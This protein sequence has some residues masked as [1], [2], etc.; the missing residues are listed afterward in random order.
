MEKTHDPAEAKEHSTQVA[1]PP[2]L[3]WLFLEVRSR[4]TAQ[5]FISRALYTGHSGPSGRCV[6]NATCI[7]RENVSLSA[8]A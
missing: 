3:W 6:F 1:G 4:P 8:D 5:S 2:A 7:N